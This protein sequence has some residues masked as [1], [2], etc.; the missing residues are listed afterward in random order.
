MAMAIFLDRDGVLNDLVFNPTTGEYESPHFPEDLVVIDGAVEALR[1][2]VEAGFD[3]FLVSN[4][5]SFAKGKATLESIEEIHR[6]LDGVLMANGIEFREYFYCFHH[7]DG[8][9]PSHS[10]PCRC[11]KPAPYFLFEAARRHGVDLGSSWMVGDQATDV[12]CGRAAGCRTA[13]V[14]NE[15][16]IA[17]REP[18]RPDV[19]VGTVSEAA[20]LIVGCLE[21]QGER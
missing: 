5:P 10:G 21:V 8:V 16:S 14:C 2:F 15:H 9:E 3:L 18:C 19:R 4:Q 17:K 12:E 7:P 13:L 6:R 20:D 11:R 1:R